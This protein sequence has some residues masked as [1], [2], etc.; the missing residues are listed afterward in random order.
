MFKDNT[1]GTS[2]ATIYVF[3]PIFFSM[4]GR[5]KKI[6]IDQGDALIISDTVRAISNCSNPVSELLRKTGHLQ[7]TCTNEILGQKALRHHNFRRQKS[8]SS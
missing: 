8:A 7:S 5:E 1:K 2:A 3:W 6:Y 4:I